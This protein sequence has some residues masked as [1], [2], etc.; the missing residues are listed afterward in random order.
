[1]TS[2]PRASTSSDSL[3]PVTILE[4][5]T[6]GDDDER[7]VSRTWDARAI[8]ADVE[9]FHAQR[10]ASDV[11]GLPLSL[12]KAYAD[13]AAGHAAVRELEPGVF[14]A[15]VVGLEGAWGDGDSVKAALDS[16][17]EA[18]VGWVA[19]KRR[20]GAADIPQMEGL[21]LNPAR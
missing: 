21:D 1:M 7:H 12:V 4:R 18:I 2:K 3:K 15:T 14:V 20:L 17:R 9:A 6:Y 16:L 8:D 13:L 19:V 5:R 10:V 11:E